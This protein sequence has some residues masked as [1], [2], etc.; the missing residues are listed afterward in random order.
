M[1]AA[2]IMRSWKCPAN[3][4]WQLSCIVFARKSLRICALALF[5]ALPLD[6][7]HALWYSFKVMHL[8]QCA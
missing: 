3:N 4:K 8:Q 6:H 7:M 5:A 1:L 2:N